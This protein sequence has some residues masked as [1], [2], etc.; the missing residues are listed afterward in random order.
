[1]KAEVSKCKA[2]RT[3]KK[4][5]RP[6]CLLLLLQKSRAKDEWLGHAGFPAG[7]PCKY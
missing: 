4:N 3:K 6:C 2:K 7:H 5:D 1:M